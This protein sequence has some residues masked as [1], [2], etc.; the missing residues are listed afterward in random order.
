[1]FKI[2][3]LKK[4]TIGKVIVER[5]IGKR[6]SCGDGD[7][8]GSLVGTIILLAVCVH[9]ILL[10]LCHYFIKNDNYSIQEMF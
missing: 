3:L 5:I 8:N 2:Y 1:M 9:E 6:I 7:V 10:Y 4:E